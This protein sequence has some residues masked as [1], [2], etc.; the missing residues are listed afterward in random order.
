[1]PTFKK[2]RVR[3]LHRQGLRFAGPVIREDDDFIT[4]YDLKSQHEIALR[5]TD[6]S[7]VEE[8]E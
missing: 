7:I 6:L 4:I 2:R 1:M 3:V 8:I 5:R